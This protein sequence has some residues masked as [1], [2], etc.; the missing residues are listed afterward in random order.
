MQNFSYAHK[1]TQFGERETATSA[2]NSPRISTK[3]QNI[4]E[5]GDALKIKLTESER[6]DHPARFALVEAVN[7]HDAALTFKPIH[8]LLKTDKPQLFC[9]RFKTSG[10]ATAYI[11]TEVKSAKFLSMPIFLPAY[12]KRTI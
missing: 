1:N 5:D 4:R 11:V 2:F 3:I 9:S 7:V 6:K 8:R 10:G 12:A